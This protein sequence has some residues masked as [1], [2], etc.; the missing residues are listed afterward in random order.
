MDERRSQL[1]SELEMNQVREK[2]LVAALDEQRR[3]LEAERSHRAE[4]LRNLEKL[5]HSAEGAAPGQATSDNAAR[6]ARTVGPARCG[7][8]PTNQ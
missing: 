7:S 4:E 5:Q 2:E 6:G 8:W 3:T 1:A